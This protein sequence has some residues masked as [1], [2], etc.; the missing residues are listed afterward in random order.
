MTAKDERALLELEQRRW[1][2]LLASNPV[3]LGELLSDELSYTHSTGHVDSK[4][5]YVTRIVSGRLIVRDVQT[6]GTS[7]RRV[8]DTA[9]FTGRAR[10]DVD[11]ESKHVVF[12]I[13]YSTVWVLHADGHWRMV[14]WHST[15]LPAPEPA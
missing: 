5:S 1:A 3:V 11:V 4:D 12:N 8:A 6:D 7:V 13:A 2:A 9:V 15:P 14:C 10:M